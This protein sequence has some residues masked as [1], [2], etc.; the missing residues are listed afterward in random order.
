MNDLLNLPRQNNLRA[1]A[2]VM[3]SAF[4]LSAC[5]A[6]SLGSST[7]PKEVVNGERKSVLTLEDELSVE[8]DSTKTEVRLPQITGNT[9]WS[10]P[11][12]NPAH[13]MGHLSLGGDLKAIWRT[14]IGAGT[15][16]KSRISASP[17]LAGGRI[18]ALDAKTH[19][20]AIDATSG[21]KIWR[22]NLTP[23]EERAADGAGGGLAYDLERIFVAT[24]FGEVIALEAETGTEIWRRSFSV[25]F[26]SSPTVT[27]GRVYVTGVNNQLHALSAFDGTSLWS[28][29]SLTEDEGIF[30]DTSPA[31]VDDLVVAPFTSGEIAALRVQNGRQAWTD[32]LTRTGTVSAISNLKVIAARPVVDRGQVIAVSHSGR[33]VAIDIRSGERIWSRTVASI[34]TPWVAGNMIFLVSLDGEV[35]ALSRS[36]G[37]VQWL[38]QLQKNSDRRGRKP[39]IWVG[40]VLAGNQMIVLSSH[41]KMVTMSPYTG[42]IIRESDI[43]SGVFVSPMVAGETFYFLNN[44][45]NVVAMQGSGSVTAEQ[46]QAMKPKVDEE[47]K[48]VAKNKPGFFSRIGNIF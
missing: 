31:V 35:M 29:R 12:G 27:G 9:D 5:S 20:A 19:V 1:M 48:A 16:S 40:P 18:F 24:G 42:A 14:S 33:I 11:G 28:H 43:G 26:H 36:D 47:G 13:S 39:I 30:S 37:K 44:K 41:G 21:K 23:E 3:V 15:S 8:S 45:G 2:L 6:F 7:K 25:P 46:A 38:T 4:V 32:A 22:T 34:Q 17:V 10:Q